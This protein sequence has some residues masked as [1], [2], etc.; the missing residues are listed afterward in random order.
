MLK[1]GDKLPRF[2]LNDQNENIVSSDQFEG[3][4]LLLSWHPL[5][6]TSVCTDQMRD[7]AKNYEEITAKGYVPLGF[8]VDTQPAKFVWANSIGI[9]YDEIKLLSDF[10]PFGAYAKELGIFSEDIGASERV[11][12]LVDE[13]GVVTWIKVYEK[14][15]YPDFDEVLANL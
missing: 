9:D 14:S 10:N 5:G 6:F 3:K 15:E 11:N 7:L 12:I 2:E 13:N 4:K 8:S 1:V